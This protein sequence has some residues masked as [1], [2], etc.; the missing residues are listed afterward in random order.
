MRTLPSLLL[1]ALAAALL[2]ACQGGTPWGATPR[3]IPLPQVPRLEEIPAHVEAGTTAGAQRIAERVRAA[4][5]AEPGL[6]GAQ[7]GVEGF[8]GGVMVLSGTLPSADARVLA[9]RTARGIAGVRDVV[10]RMS[11][12]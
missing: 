12:P 7:L 2:T 11:A 9:V 10:D 4:L 1:S 8:E 3:Q 5:A 6:A